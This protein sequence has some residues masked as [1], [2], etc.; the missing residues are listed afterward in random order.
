[1]SRSTALPSTSY[2]LMDSIMLKP[3]AAIVNVVAHGRYVK[4]RAVIDPSAQRSL[5][6]EKVVRRLGAKTIRIG[7]SE[8]VLLT[9]RGKYGSSDT[10]ETYAE[11][12]KQ[13]GGLISSKWVDLKRAEKFPGL[14]LA[15]PTFFVSAPVGIKLGCDAYSKI[16]RNDVFGDAMGK[17]L[18]QFSAT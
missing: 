12:R 11:V 9:I 7:R 16:I 1:M 18:A 5:F 3:T 13:L 15:D 2:T 8:R 4:E 17:P 6:A 14:Q 10:V